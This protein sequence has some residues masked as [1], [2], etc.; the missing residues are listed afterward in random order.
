M[1][2]PIQLGVHTWN[3]ILYKIDQEQTFHPHEC[4]IVPVDIMLL[5]IF[6]THPSH[7]TF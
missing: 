1:L 6:D 7:T 4:S 5:C 3:T 2:A